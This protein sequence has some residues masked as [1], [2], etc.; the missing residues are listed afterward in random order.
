MSALQP[1]GNQEKRERERQNKCRHFL[2]RQSSSDVTIGVQA[3]THRPVVKFENNF[4][5][6]KSKKARGSGVV[7]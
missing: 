3:M 1:L 6:D 7:Y 5:S 4:Q 2:S